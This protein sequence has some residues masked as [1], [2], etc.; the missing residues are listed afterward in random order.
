M[1]EKTQTIPYPLGMLTRIYTFIP[2]PTL[3]TTPNGI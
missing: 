2:R 3:L 1:G